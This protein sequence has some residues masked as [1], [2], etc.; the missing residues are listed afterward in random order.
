MREQRVK[1]GLLFTF[2][3]ILIFI[4][5]TPITSAVEFRIITESY[6]ID[7]INSSFDDDSGWDFE[8]TGDNSDVEFMIGDVSKQAEVKVVGD[9]RTFNMVNSTP[10]VTDWTIIPNPLIPNF[11]DFY[12]I[13]SSGFHVSHNW[14]EDQDS[15]SNNP[16]VRWQ[17]DI[18]MPADMSEYEITAVNL[19]AIFNAAVEDKKLNLSDPDNSEN[20]GGIEVSGDATIGFW[21]GSAFEPQFASGDFARFYILMSD[22]ENNKEYRVAFN[23][24]IDLGQDK[25]V[26][27]NITDNLINTVDDSALIFY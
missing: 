20:N 23:Q 1:S 4:I 22:L 17:R 2:I 9:S 16:S 15:T 3:F 21:N 11:P 27:I 26:I 5:Q 24:T 19:S 18:N 14:S 25:P 10:H 12:E 7:W 6:D 13:N 8:V